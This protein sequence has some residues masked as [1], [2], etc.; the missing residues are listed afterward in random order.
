MSAVTVSEKYQVVIPKAVRDALDIR[1]GQKIE[2]IVYEGRAEFVP[3]RDM[4]AM[5]GFLR[6]MDTGFA[7]DKDRV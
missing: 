5:R 1:P 6:G 7:R 2:V 4:K 3:V